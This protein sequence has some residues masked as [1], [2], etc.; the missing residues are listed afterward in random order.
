MSLLSILPVYRAILC[1]LTILLIL[2]YIV[3]MVLSFQQKN[4]KVF[5]MA[6]FLLLCSYAV[7]QVL[8]SV[9][10]F[11]AFGRQKR[12]AEICGGLSVTVCLTIILLL[13]AL[14]IIIFHWLIMWKRSH[15][16][17]GSVKESID[18][19]PTGLAI[20]EEDG[21]CL[22][23]NRTMNRISVV[24]TGQA[25]MNGLVLERAAREHDMLIDMGGRKYQITHHMIT[26]DN[27]NIHELV[28]DDVTELHQKTQALRMS[29]AEL[30]DMAQKM[31]QYSL[32]IDESVRKQEILQAKVNIHDEMN[33]LLLATGNAANGSVSPEELQKILHTWKNNA[34]LLC[35][36]ADREPAG[37]TQQDLQT[38]A[39]IIGIKLVWDGHL[40]TRDPQVLQIFERA[41]REAMNNAVKHAK[42]T[43]LYI[44]L[45]KSET[46]L[47]ITY[48]NNG[49]RPSGGIRPAGGLKN[50][51]SILE[52][53]GGA[54]SVASTP[55]YNLTVKIPKGGKEDAL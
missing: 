50:L 15:V 37:N 46:E 41:T 16:S 4:R 52:R 18:N 45:R 13:F 39:D 32:N 40:G 6:S 27:R 35:K 20:Y 53:V 24:L 44:R 48:T 19:L 38:L 28:A 8:K 22:L 1:F 31:K 36:E 55:D 9:I 47:N 29:N 17:Q 11:Q 7:H 25:V 10:F 30:A 23:V 42:A 21:S 14:S 12:M 26:L 54:M 51:Q 3:D 5:L 34:L 49:L 33:R 2:L 43:C